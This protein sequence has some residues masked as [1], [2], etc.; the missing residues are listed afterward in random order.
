MSER[1]VVC[2]DEVHITRAVSM[3]LRKAGFDVETAC[4]GQQGW[5]TIERGQPA[6]LMTDFQMPQ[7]D[8]LELIERLRAE[9]SYRNLPIILLTAKGF[10]VDAAELSRRFDPLRVMCKPFS[11]KEVVESVEEMI[12]TA[13]FDQPVAPSAELEH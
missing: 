11:L 4:N 7:M 10:E 6:L 1:I 3:K 8:G 5:E 12:R 13:C 9:P 2:D